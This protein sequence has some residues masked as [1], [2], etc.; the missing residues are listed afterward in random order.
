MGCRDGLC[1]GCKSC[2]Q[3]QGMWDEDDDGTGCP[4]PEEAL[5]RHANGAVE[6]RQCETLLAEPIGG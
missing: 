4:H 3:A 5:V 6:C 2:L 1:G